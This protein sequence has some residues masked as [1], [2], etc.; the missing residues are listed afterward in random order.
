M[1]KGDNTPFLW[2]APLFEIF[3]NVAGPN[4]FDKNRS[5][6]FPMI[7]TQYILLG[8]ATLRLEYVIV[9]F[10]LLRTGL[11]EAPLSLWEAPKVQTCGDSLRGNQSVTQ[12]RYHR[13]VVCEKVNVEASHRTVH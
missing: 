13:L 9:P 11:W 6:F 3:E 4:I 2:S 12:R 8:G 5:M 1:E 7:M 10:A